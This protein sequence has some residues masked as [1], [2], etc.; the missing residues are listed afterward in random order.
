MAINFV[1]N[2]LNARKEELQLR[3]DRVLLFCLIVRIVFGSFGAA[4]EIPGLN[5]P[6]VGVSQSR[7]LRVSSKPI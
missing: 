5:P 1:V 3:N 6:G 7:R 4:V 2:I